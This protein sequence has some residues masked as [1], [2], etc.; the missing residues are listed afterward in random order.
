MKAMTFLRYFCVLCNCTLL[1]TYY[2]S[3]T[4]TKHEACKIRG[5]RAPECS[6]TVNLQL[7]LWVHSMFCIILQVWDLIAQQWKYFRWSVLVCLYLHC[8]FPRLDYFVSSLYHPEETFC[9]DDDCGVLVVIVFPYLLLTLMFATLQCFWQWPSA[10][11]PIRAV[12]K[13][14]TDQA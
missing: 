4:P 5:D 3:D 10:D 8:W 11:G 6:F 9:R 2:F 12:W 13:Y 1:G 7:Y 14:F